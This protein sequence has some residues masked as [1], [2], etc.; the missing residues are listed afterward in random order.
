MKWLQPLVVYAAPR[1]PDAD[2]HACGEK[3]AALLSD[4]AA[5]SSVQDEVR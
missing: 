2:L 4:F 5:R 3:Y 1:V